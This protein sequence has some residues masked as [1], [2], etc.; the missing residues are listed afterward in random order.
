[1]MRRA[2]AIGLTCFAL[3]AS[4]GSVTHAETLADVRRDLATLLAEM[5]QLDDELVSSGGSLVIRSGS[6][7]D[8][9]AAIEEELRRVTRAVERL[10]FRIENVVRDGSNRIGDLEFRVCEQEPGCEITSLGSTLPLGQ[11]DL[12]PQEVS[13][14]TAV[15][16]TIAEQREF[17]QAKEALEQGDVGTALVLFEDFTNSYPGGPLTQ[18]A[19]LLSGQAATENGTHKVAARAYLSAYA[20]NPTGTLASDALFQLSLSFQYL[21]NTRE[22]CV[23]LQEVASRFPTSVAASAAQGAM[24]EFSC[25]K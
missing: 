11:V 18:E 15:I 17:D 24:T 8:R 25:P 2:F 22:A 20:E 13:T 4:T 6:I 9:T 23:T 10:E 1:M 16:M 21:G 7:L 14:P 5:K 19:Y 12:T 3:V